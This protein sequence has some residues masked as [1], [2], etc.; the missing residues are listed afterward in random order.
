MM[1]TMTDPSPRLRTALEGRYTIEKELGE[2]GMALVYL[3]RDG[4]EPGPVRRR[5]LRP[6]S[7]IHTLEAGRVEAESPPSR[8]D[9]VP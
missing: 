9:P 4:R 3:A 8:I 1:G 7:G 6:I 2:G 5:R